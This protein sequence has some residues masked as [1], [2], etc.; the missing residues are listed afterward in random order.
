VDRTIAPVT[1]THPTN[2]AMIYTGTQTFTG[3][4]DTTIATVTITGSGFIPVPT[5]ASCSGGVYSL[6]VSVINAGTITVSQSDAAGNTSSATSVY[7]LTAGGSGGG[8]TGYSATSGG[9]ETTTSTPT[10]VVTTPTVTTTPLSITGTGTTYISPIDGTTQDCRPFTTYL[11]IGKKNN[12]TEVKLWQ[13]FLNKH[14]SENLTISGTYNKTTEAAIK[15]FQSKYTTEILTPWGLTKPT[16]YTYQ[17]TRAQGNK[18][19]GCSEGN[20]TL[21]NGVVIK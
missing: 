14:M 2:G 10:P 11:K 8:S 6:A 1:L 4:C 18:I 13:A 21:D 5:T 7:T 15:R 20:V 3:T 19:L 17:S 9:K 12:T 16:G